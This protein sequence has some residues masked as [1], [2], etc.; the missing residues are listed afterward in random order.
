MFHVVDLLAVLD[1]TASFFI[2]QGEELKIVQENGVKNGM[3]TG[4]ARKDAPDRV[5]RINAVW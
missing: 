1:I 5:N 3:K 4:R 2:L